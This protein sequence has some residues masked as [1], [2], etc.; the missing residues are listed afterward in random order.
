MKKRVTI[1]DVAR[2][3]HV[4]VATV[5]LV[6][7]GRAGINIETRKRVEQMARALGYQRR[8]SHREH[9][10]QRISV[11][12]RQLGNT[13]L[14][15]Q[16][17]DD[18]ILRGVEDVCRRRG[19]RDDVRQISLAQNGFPAS[20]LFFPQYEYDGVIGIGV[21]VDASLHKQIRDHQLPFVSVDGDVTAHVYDAVMASYHMAIQELVE[22][23]TMMGHR[24]VAVIDEPIASSNWQ[25]ALGSAIAGYGM[26]EPSV[27][28]CE[29]TTVDV[30]EMLQQLLQRHP[31]TSV[32]VCRTHRLA[33]HVIEQL[34]LF[35]RFVPQH[36]SVVGFDDMYHDTASTTNLTTIRIDARALGV[37]AVQTLL[38]RIEWPDMPRVITTIDAALVI[39]QSTY[40]H[41]I[42]G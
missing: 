28:A 39:R 30:Q 9:H 31:Q 40:V 5:S 1:E 10:V 6:M 38:N 25:H 13:T 19:I 42:H 33:L 8:K 35:G 3:S 34:S 2:A 14:D 29:L 23:L 32:I 36:I 16:P 12:M 26:I 15:A 37:L 11:L 41:P 22:Y 17:L 27:W 20:P 21:E 24:A 18:G 4:S 7:R